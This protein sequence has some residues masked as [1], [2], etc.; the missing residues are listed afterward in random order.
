MLSRLSI[1]NFKSL[2]DV[3]VEF[4]SK[5][6]VLIGLNGSGKSTLLQ[7]VDFLASLMKENGVE[8]WLGSRGWKKGELTSNLGKKRSP[9]ITFDAFFEE[10]GLEW[11]WEG[12]YNSSLGRC[13]SES[14][15][16]SADGGEKLCS[17]LK[18]GEIRF[19][20]GKPIDSKLFHQKGSVFSLVR[21]GSTWLP[22]QRLDR[23]NVLNVLSIDLLSPEQMR[24]RPRVGEVEGVGLGGEQL[25]RCLHR[26]SA[27]R[28]ETLKGVMK[29]FYPRF[30]SF[31]TKPLRGG[32]VMLMVHEVFDG[33][34]EML[35]ESR[36][37]N[38]GM[39]RVLAIVAETLFA[40]GTVLIDEV[41]DGINPELLEKLTQYLLEDCPCQVIVTTHSPL[42]LNFLPDEEAEKRVK[43]VYKTGDGGTK[44]VPFF[45]ISEMKKSLGVLGP[46]EVMLQYDMQEVAAMAEEMDGST[47]EDV[48]N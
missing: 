45:K 26:F 31:E 48:E 46:G 28:K 25:S 20:N 22:F 37:V 21:F 15:T 12:V 6:N 30:D 35:T 16:Y 18:D 38:D 14:L 29:R 5:L 7:G 11:S 8:R 27:E 36:H 9:L 23:E 19:P 43:F 3:E 4:S 13:T 32:G 42:L 44:V 41:E 10:D 40:E 17:E 47:S 33:G 2:R 39:L 24:R 34:Y 1:K